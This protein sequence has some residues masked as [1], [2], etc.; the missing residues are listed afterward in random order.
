M[1]SA[2]VS[3]LL[4]SLVTFL[5]IHSWYCRQKRTLISNVNGATVF[6]DL[7]EVSETSMIFSGAQK[8]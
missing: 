8:E 7:L 6:R 2:P 1:I 3:G 4:L 5:A